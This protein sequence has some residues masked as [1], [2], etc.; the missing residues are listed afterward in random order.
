MGDCTALA[1][2][3]VSGVSSGSSRNKTL[4][5]LKLFLIQRKSLLKIHRISRNGAEI[6]R[7][8]FCKSFFMGY[9]PM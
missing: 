5:P 7:H 2:D 4:K 1:K 9:Q 6:T 8:I 3:S